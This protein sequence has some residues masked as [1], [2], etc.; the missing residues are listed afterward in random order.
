MEEGEEEEEVEVVVEAR[1]LLRM[2]AEE[3]MEV[4][5]EISTLVVEVVVEVLEVNRAFFV[6]CSSASVDESS[7]ATTDAEEEQ[8]AGAAAAA[9]GTKDEVLSFLI[10][11]FAGETTSKLE[12]NSVQSNPPLLLSLNHY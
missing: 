6:G 3:T 1:R 7:V 8:P 12:P 10:D 2:N 4:L 5:L 9:V 11:M